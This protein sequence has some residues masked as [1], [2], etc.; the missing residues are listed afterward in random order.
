[1]TRDSIFISYSHQDKM[2]L[3]EIKKYLKVLEHNHKMIIWDDT[4]IKVGNNWK[5]EISQSIKRSKVAILLVSSNF[6][7]SEFIAKKELPNI[8]KS[9]RKE[10][11]I[12][13]NVIIDVCTYQLTELS[14]FQCLNNPEYPLE[15][16]ELRERKKVLVKLATELLG[17]VSD[18]SDDEM[19]HT[20]ENLSNEQD[21]FFYKILVLAYLVKTG[22][23]PITE[24]Q[25]KILCRRK[26]VV[27]V[28]EKLND[29]GYLEKFNGIYQKKTSSLWKASQLGEN[30]F[31]RFE[32]IYNKI[33]NLPE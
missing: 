1:M 15:D 19:T 13:F 9:A 11:L 27:A 30:I 28:L 18:E 6:I 23:K 20:A 8:L 31:L 26:M 32:T 16:L 3:E 14:A 10:G 25:N 17:V 4:E 12:I 29:H 7:A 22:A 24:I 2:W 21:I 33:I 5:N